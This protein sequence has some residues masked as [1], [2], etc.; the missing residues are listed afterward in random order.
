MK[1]QD[2]PNWPKRRPI[3]IG[4]SRQYAALTTTARQMPELWINFNTP[5]HCAKEV[6]A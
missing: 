3:I 1:Q 2:F 5:P 6:Q 4:L